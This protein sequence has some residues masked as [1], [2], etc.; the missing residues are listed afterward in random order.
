MPDPITVLV[1]LLPFFQLVFFA[2]SPIPWAVFS[3]RGMVHTDVDMHVR[4]DDEMVAV[5]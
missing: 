1:V 2:L 5:G 4:L 3:V